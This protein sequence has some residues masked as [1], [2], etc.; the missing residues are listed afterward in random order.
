[1]SHLLDACVFQD[2]SRLGLSPLLGNILPEPCYSGRLQ[3]ARNTE[4][5]PGFCARYRITEP[6]G[7]T[8]AGILQ[9]TAQLQAADLDYALSDADLG[10]GAYALVT[11]YTLLTGDGALRRLVQRLGGTVENTVDVLAGGVQAGACT[12]KEACDALRRMLAF[13]PPRRGIPRQAAQAL[14]THLGS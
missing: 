11:G 2:F 7:L 13:Q 12:P 10:I 9:A 8:T 6:P 4:L 14:L 5:S 3:I 1:M